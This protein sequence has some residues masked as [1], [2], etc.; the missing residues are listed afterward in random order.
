MLYPLEGIKVLDLSQFLSGPRCTQLLAD[1]GAEVVKLEGPAGETMRLWMKLIP[2]QEQSFSNWHRS[3][4]GITLNLKHPEGVAL[5]KKLVPHFDVLVENLA[6]GALEEMG[7]GYDELHKLHPGLIYCSISGFGRNAPLSHRPA[8]DLIAQ[9]TGGIMA[10]QNMTSRSPGVFFGDLVSGAYAAFGIL[11]AL[12]F[13]EA[14]GQGQLVDVSMQDVMY[15]H[16]FRSLQLRS[17]QGEESA[18]DEALGGSF[19]DLFTSG[20][21]M[22]FWRP[23]A[24]QD[25]TIAVV[26]LTDKQWKTMA[27]LIGRPEL[28]DDPRFANFVTRVK[29]REAVRQAL[30]DWMKNKSVREIE[31]LLDQN[32]IPCG[33]VLSCDEVNEDANLKARGMIA[34]VEDSDHA[35]V[36]TPGVPI[37]LSASPGALRSAAPKLGEHNQMI[38]GQLLGL[39][40][41]ELKSLKAKG[42]I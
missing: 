15:F 2:G 18:M 23:Y 16:N 10:A 30:A 41:S 40:E 5:F 4:Q 27:D 42:V 34:F 9:A 7:A 6:P 39:S 19:D 21:G 26:F 36:P 38:L 13:R 31:Q 25:G 32:N 22:P 11:A 37:R 33:V 20:E 12:R 29:N 1:L 28:K 17:A 3:K 24:A 35:Q 8:F 14:T